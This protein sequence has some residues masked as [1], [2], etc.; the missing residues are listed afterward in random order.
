LWLPFTRAAAVVVLSP[1][2]EP[3]Y[4]QRLRADQPEGLGLVAAG[5]TSAAIAGRL[6]LS[7]KTVEVDIASTFRTLDVPIS[8]IVNRR[9]MAVVTLKSS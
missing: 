6:Y 3:R 7:E 2:L 1:H 5:L 8:P 4:S 9:V